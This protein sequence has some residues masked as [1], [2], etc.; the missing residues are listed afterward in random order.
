MNHE[1]RRP[2]K[3]SEKR[4][5]NLVAGARQIREY[6]ASLAY[7]LKRPVLNQSSIFGPESVQEVFLRASRFTKIVNN[8]GVSL[9]KGNQAIE[10]AEQAEN[11]L[12]V[13]RELKHVS[14]R[15]PG[16]FEVIANRVLTVGNVDSEDGLK[17]IGLGLNMRSE[18]MILR[19]Q[20][21][22]MRHFGQNNFSTIIPHVSLC[23]T[24]RQTEIDVIVDSLREAME[25]PIELELGK[26]EIFS[27]VY[28]FE[29]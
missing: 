20:Q 21:R 6:D 23:Y 4:A 12:E 19:D 25:F 14:R 24:T 29:Q 15:M 2:L 11:I 16:N 5:L 3:K 10:I 28:N 7:S 9:I 1:K 8:I 17:F 22:I 27:N 26:P 13:R 18:N